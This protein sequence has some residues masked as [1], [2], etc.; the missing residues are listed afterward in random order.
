MKRRNKSI[1]SLFIFVTKL[2]RRNTV[3][4]TVRLLGSLGLMKIGV[5]SLCSVTFGLSE[6]PLTAFKQRPGRWGTQ[7]ELTL[8]MTFTSQVQIQ[9]SWEEGV[10]RTAVISYE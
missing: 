3:S 4:V 6:I 8:K 5:S 9:L 2:M 1:R 10:V 7:V